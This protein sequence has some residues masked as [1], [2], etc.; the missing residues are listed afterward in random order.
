MK[1]K[2]RNEVASSATFRSAWQFVCDDVLRAIADEPTPI[3]S[4]SLVAVLV[5]AISPAALCE[6]V[7]NPRARMLARVF[8][9][10]YA[11]DPGLVLR[12]L[13]I[14]REKWNDQSVQSRVEKHIV[15]K[16][17]R[18]AKVEAI[19]VAVFGTQSVGTERVSDSAVKKAYQRI[20]PI[21]SNRNPRISRELHAALK[22]LQ[23]RNIYVGFGS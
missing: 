17:F 8:T 15:T 9:E 7:A 22:E 21:E 20:K 4:D 13:N 23:R 16:V 3:G 18:D 6:A 1:R 10:I 2:P 12:L 14:I 5:V 11:H 19:H